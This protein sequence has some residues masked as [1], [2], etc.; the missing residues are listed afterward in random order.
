MTENGR[1]LEGI[2]VVEAATM[3]LVPST[4]VALAD[5]GAE[6]IK[7]EAPGA[8]DP[9]RVMHEIP[10]LP[11]SEIP[12]SFLLDNRNKKSL[13]L[14]LKTEGGREILHELIR[15]A[16][17]FLT[18]F[19]PQAVAK[20]RLRYE[21]LSPLNPRLVYAQATGFGERGQEATKPAYDMVTYWSRSGLEASMFPIEGWLG[22][23]PS[24]TGD[25]PS[26]MSL[27]GAI[28]AGLYTRERT[29]RGLKVS[30]S[31]LANGVWTNGTLIQAK[32][33]G[34]RFHDKRPREEALYFAGVY[35][36]SGDGRIFKMTIA[37]IEKSWAPL[38]RAVGQAEWIDDPRFATNEARTRHTAELISLLDRIFAEKD[39]EHWQS[40]LEANDIPHSVLST[41]DEVVDDPQLAS[42]D[43]FA[44]LDHP[45]FGRMRTIN[46]PVCLEGT[47]KVRPEAAP[48]LG[49]HSDEILAE[50]GFSELEIG[51][52]VRRG[53]V[54]RDRG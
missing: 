2:R 25:H 23:I 33:C 28:M 39:M 47:E 6:V 34:A 29:G 10:G 21:D 19:R 13:A 16:D 5:F 14:D 32:L 15:R 7:I 54:G 40:A 43:V 17:V 52:F 9:H 4:A 18:N 20:L 38:C 1:P 42:N 41:Y 22:P 49:Q 35:Y 44:E 48:S 37:N 50:L 45:Q 31:L 12:Y 27:F 53:V 11:Q 51:D 26:A 46:T 24:G 30:T 36:R 3:L 8:P